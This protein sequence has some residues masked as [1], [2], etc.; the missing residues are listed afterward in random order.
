MSEHVIGHLPAVLHELDAV[1]L[2]HRPQRP[3]VLVA[4]DGLRVGPDRL[5]RNAPVETA[6]HNI[7]RRAAAELGDQLLQ[8]FGLAEIVEQH[9]VRLVGN[10]QV[11]RPAVREMVGGRVARDLLVDDLRRL[12]EPL[13][14]QLGQQVSIAQP[15]GKARPDRPDQQRPLGVKPLLQLLDGQ[16]HLPTVA[17][18]RRGL[19][20]R[21]PLGR[22]HGRRLAA[23]S[24]Q[25]PETN[26]DQTRP[27]SNTHLPTTDHDCSSRF[28]DPMLRVCSEPEADPGSPPILPSRVCSRRLR[29]LLR[30][31]G[32]KTIGR[33]VDSPWRSYCNGSGQPCIQRDVGL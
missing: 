20:L 7:G 2:A 32:R 16:R 31:F 8:V 17:G 21:R 6:H 12:R 33:S 30:R 24:R 4:V 28:L 27:R 13:P 22:L 23:Q 15:V 5:V 14:H 3:R 18:P 11:A 19:V 1:L 10:H 25:A 26:P 29:S 9:D